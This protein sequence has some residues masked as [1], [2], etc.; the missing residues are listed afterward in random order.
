MTV[1]IG[2]I[3]DPIANIKFA[4]DGTLVQLLEAQR[5]GWEIY[6][7]E[8][9]DLFLR[10]QKPQGKAKKITVFYDEKRWYEFG[11][12]E[13]IPL[14][15]LDVILMRKDPPVDNEYIFTTYLLDNAEAQGTLVINKPQSLRDANEK[16]FIQ[17]FPQCCPATLITSNKELIKDFLQQHQEIVLKPL[18]EMAGKSIFHLQK[19]D[20]NVNV[21]IETLTNNQQQKIMVQKFIP[22]IFTAGD[23]RI[24]IVDGEV[25]PYTLIRKPSGDDFRGNIAAGGQGLGGELNQRDLWLCQQIAPILKQKGLLFVGLDVIGDYV[26]E[27]NVTSPT[28]VRQIKHFFDYDIPSKIFD[29]IDKKLLENR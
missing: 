19:N 11:P 24:F 2:V 15:E 17:W 9:S 21:V 28:G 6:Y 23:K 27:I 4:T 3:M 10:D 14:A 8:Q 29:A 16:F 5:R 12:T 25:M 18:T 1:K 26:T 7:F 13:I 22:E 20:V